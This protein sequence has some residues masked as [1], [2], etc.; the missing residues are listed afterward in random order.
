MGTLETGPAYEELLISVQAQSPKRK[1][2]LRAAASA[3]DSS[4]NSDTVTIPASIV[5][6]MKSSEK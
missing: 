2:R 6:P 3:D 5:S 4:Q 1:R